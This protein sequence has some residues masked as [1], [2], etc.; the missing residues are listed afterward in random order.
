[1]SRSLR[2]VARVHA[3]PPDHNAGAEWMLHEMLRALAG[4]GHEAEVWLS[5][6]AASSRPYE[7]DGVRVVPHLAGGKGFPAVAAR[8]H[9]LVSHLE[10]VP[11]TAAVARGHGVPLITVCHNTFDLTWQP[12]VSGSTALAVANSAWMLAEARE[13]F[14]ARSCRGPDRWLVVRPPVWPGEYRTEPGECI[15]LVNCTMSKGA[16]VLSELARHLQDRKFLAVR[17]G[18]GEQQPPEWANVLV[19]DHMPGR[20]MREAVYARTR[21]LLMPSDYESWGRAGVEAMASGIPVIAHPT[22][23]LVESLGDAGIFVDR[24]DVG[25]WRAA[26]LRLDDPAVYAAAS[27]RALA[28]S[29]QLDPA[30]DL[31]AWCDAVEEVCRARSAAR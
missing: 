6:P 18:Y 20:S 1:M 10:N 14:A 22:P 16:G 4:R 2:V 13:Y 19:L 5:Q 21:V 11:F 23:G 28:R 7:V 31:S 12:M 24:A 17:G 27:R 15:T 26:V 25:A 3:Y 29:G 8:A 30:G 9:G